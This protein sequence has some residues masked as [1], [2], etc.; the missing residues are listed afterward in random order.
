MILTMI[1]P[2]NNNHIAVRQFESIDLLNRSLSNNN[3]SINILYLNA[4]SIKNKLD[5]LQAYISHIQ[6][7]T[8]IIIVTETWVEK[9]EE[10]FYNLPGYNVTYSSRTKKGGG[11]AIF[12]KNN[13]TGNILKKVERNNITYLLVSIQE[14]KT[15]F[16]AIYN[17]SKKRNDVEVTL[18][19]LEEELSRQN[20]QNVW[21][22]GDLNID[23]LTNNLNSSRIRDIC[24]SNGFYICNETVATRK[25]H[26]LIDHIITNIP[27]PQAKLGIIK[28]GISDHDLQYLSIEKEEDLKSRQL[29]YKKKIVDLQRIKCELLKVDETY[30]NTNSVDLNYEL[31][32]QCFLK[33][34]SYRDITMNVKNNNKPWFNQDIQ[35]A[36]RANDYYYKKSQLY[37]NNGYLKQ[38]YQ[39]SKKHLKNIIRNSKNEYFTRKFDQVKGNTRKEW[40][41]LNQII[42]NTDKSGKKNVPSLKIQNQTITDVK[43]ISEQFNNF[44]STVAS[45]LASKINKCKLNTETETVCNK[46]FQLQDT[47][48]LEVLKTIESLDPKKAPGHDDID[49]KTVKACSFEL[50]SILCKLLNQSFNGGEVPAGMKLARVLPLFKGGDI[51][52]PN[53]YR[54]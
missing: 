8:H 3:K 22:L 25:S 15:C 41:V 14:L 34:T 48:F 26:N 46:S 21:L 51:Q 16:S 43:N 11:C 40:Q 12:I 31:V 17:P 53:N 44:F 2:M 4:C 9:H 45:S 10:N 33:G 29:T 35:Q 38:K 37:P 39:D 42:T 18:H 1:S 6:I 20:N 19:L 49:T 7:Q 5:K 13:L 28:A 36:I 32:T 52:N 30:S 47:N 27:N 23:L 54:P 24:T 50:S